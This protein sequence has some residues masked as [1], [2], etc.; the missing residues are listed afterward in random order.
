MLQKTILTQH[1]I[2]IKLKRMAFEIAETTGNKNEFVIVGIKENGWQIAL[3]IAGLLQPL[4]ENKVTVAA[5]SLNKQLP[6]EITIDTY[7]DVNNKNVLLIDDVCNSGKTLA[8]ALKPLLQFHPAKIEILVLV[9]RVYKQFPVMPRYV[10]IS[11][12]TMLEEYIEVIIKN[13]TVMEAI[14]VDAKPVLA[15]S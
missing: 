5:L 12:A 8:Y 1:D 15:N 3:L 10:G 7:I 13:G 6:D 4:V 9:D 2:A 11:V 14:I